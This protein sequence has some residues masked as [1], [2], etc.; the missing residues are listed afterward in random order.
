MVSSQWHRLILLKSYHFLLSLNVFPLVK[1]MDHT[2]TY[3]VNI[4]LFSLFFLVKNS[5]LKIICFNE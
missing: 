5:K 3:Y 4:F 2:I 1:E